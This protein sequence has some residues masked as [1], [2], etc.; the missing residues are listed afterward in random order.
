MVDE[1]QIASLTA[2]TLAV[3]VVLTNVLLEIGK[4]DPTLRSAIKRGLSDAADSVENLATRSDAVSPDL[5]V[6]AL[7]VI[8][9][10]RAASV[11]DGPSLAPMD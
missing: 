10:M 6:K 2:E 1:K 5:I 11:G 8:E 3:Q 9:E 7:H 4:L